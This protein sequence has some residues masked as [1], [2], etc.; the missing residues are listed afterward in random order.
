MK[1][2]FNDIA[3]EKIRHWVRECSYEVSGMG[4]VQIDQETKTFTITDAFLL[5]QVGGAAHTNIDSAAISQLMDETA[6]LEGHLNFWWHSHVNMAAFWSGTDRT[7]INELGK[8]GLCVATVFNKK[9]EHL[10]AIEYQVKSDLFGTTT[11]FIDNVPTTFNTFD[12]WHE[13]RAAWTSEL[14]DKVKEQSYVS[15]LGRTKVHYNDG[16]THWQIPKYVERE[17][18]LLGMD[19]L[20]LWE[21]YLTGSKEELE[22]LDN[23]LAAAEAKSFHYWE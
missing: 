10:S 9:G 4:L 6:T 22:R 3:I 20:K 2:I 23:R 7:T 21:T 13:H 8:E 15:H 12:P 1:I 17:A 11:T 5:Q 14:K 16:M 18:N 19:A